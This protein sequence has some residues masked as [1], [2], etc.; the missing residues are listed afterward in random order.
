MTAEKIRPIGICDQCGGSIPA[1]DHYTS[2]GRP[3]LHCSP[4]CRA[5][6]N[7]RAGAPIRSRKA[8][9]RVAAGVWYNPRSEMTPEQIS[10]LQSRASR[11]ARLR[12]VAESRWCN[13][14]LAAAAR[15]KLSRSR[16][17]RGLLARAIDKAN[18][19]GMADLTPAE[20]RAYLRW[21]QELRDKRR[22]T[23]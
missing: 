20:H 4:T 15:R 11:K 19:G 8:R 9:E 16:K 12:E 7:S 5:T 13:P 21:R 17:H 2:K 22:K 18:R 23:Q 1:A 3:R 10:A 14:A 6:A